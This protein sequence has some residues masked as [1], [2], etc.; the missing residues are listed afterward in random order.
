MI[1][2]RLVLMKSCFSLGVYALYM[3]GHTVR[4]L[5]KAK[6]SSCHNHCRKVTCLLPVIVGIPVGCHT[7]LRHRTPPTDSR[8]T[9]LLLAPSTASE[10]PSFQASSCSA[11]Q[12]PSR[13]RCNSHTKVQQETRCF[14]FCR[15][16][17]FDISEPQL[18]IVGPRRF[19]SP[20][21]N[22]IRG[23]TP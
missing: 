18:S 1:F 17:G 3:I 19:R 23:C 4:T 16:S 21:S 20:C 10:R 7:T 15:D 13:K 5:T 11:T 2:F 8:P 14:K 9:S 22:Y 6:G 12:S